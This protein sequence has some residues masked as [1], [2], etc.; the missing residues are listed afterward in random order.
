MAE[1]SLMSMNQ[2]T[3][4]NAK[5]KC[6][7]RID[8]EKK[9]SAPKRSL[10]KKLE[11]ARDAYE[12]A[13][14]KIDK[15]VT[16]L[17]ETTPTGETKNLY[18]LYFEG[19]TKTTLTLGYIG[20]KLNENGLNINNFDSVGQLDDNDLHVQRDFIDV[21]KDACENFAHGKG[22]LAGGLTKALI[23]V[24]VGELLARGVTA[25]LAH[26]G[27]MEAS[28]GLLGLAE[29]GF[30][31]LNITNISSAFEVIGSAI[32]TAATSAWT[33]SP[34]LVIAVPTLLAV[35]LLPVVMDKCH[36]MIKKFNANKDFEKD[37]EKMVSNQ[38]E[39]GPT[40]AP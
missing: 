19:K 29:M 32:S 22:G 26:N 6:Q 38:P 14:K 3:L 25:I 33:F 5:E 16:K 11:T 2:D 24:S 12:S 7:E 9:K 40:V 27:I 37:I 1:L 39:L 4:K 10:I 23:G 34:L 15:I 30:S 13:Y 17:K 36:K 28:T 35:K 20:S 21:T 31:S 8:K 18:D